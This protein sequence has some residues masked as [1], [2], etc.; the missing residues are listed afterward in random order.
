MEWMIYGA[1]GYTGQLVVA[2]ALARGHRPLLA[3]R[4]VEKLEALAE[5]TGLEYAAFHLDDVAT[6]GEAI[7]DMDVV[8]H[9]AGPFVRTSE[10]MIRACL[11]TRTH[12]LDITGEIPVFEQTFSYDQ[13]ARQN[14]IALISGVGF[15]VIPTDCLGMYVAQQVA[16]PTQLEIAFAGFENF[17]AGTM[18]SVLS[19]LPAGGYMRR[20]GTLYQGGFGSETRQVTFNNEQDHTTLLIPWG[21]AA[22][23]YRSTAIPN[24]TTYMGMPGG[25]IALTR[26]LLPLARLLLQSSALRQLT[27]QVIDRTMSGPAT[28]ARD[29]SRTHLWAQVTNEMGHTAQAWLETSEP[30]TFTA[31][32]APL[33]VERTLELQPLGALTPAQAFGADFVLEVADTHRYDTL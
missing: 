15:D 25:M 5:E 21:D 32:V 4:N 26:A 13:I 31:Q 23:S 3:G 28:N 27:E 12:Y 10:P 19:M 11:A 20:D 2:A 30:Y 7:A 14:G 6:I 22:T 17:S 1:T 24:I 9:A 29:A 8:Y 16:N 18:K 33:V